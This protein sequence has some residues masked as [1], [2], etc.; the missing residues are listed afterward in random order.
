MGGYVFTADIA[1][2]AEIKVSSPE[3]DLPSPAPTTVLDVA[4]A[5]AAEATTG[6]ARSSWLSAL[7]GRM[8]ITAAAALCAIVGLAAAAPLLRSNLIFKRSPPVVAVMAMADASGDP[9]G[10]VMA[11]E[12]AGR[13]TDGLARI[14][15]ISV[16]APRSTAPQPELAASLA[17]P[18]D[19]EIRGELQRSGPSWTLR[20]RLIQ[21]T[22]GKVEAV[23]AVAVDA[24]ERDPL[25]QQTRLAAGVGDVLARRLNEL[26]ETG[27]SSA[28]GGVTAG[29]ARAAIEQATASINSVTQERFSMAQTMLQNA[30]AEQPDNVDAAVALAALQMRGIQMVWYSPDAAAAAEAQAAANLERALRAKP[31]SIAVLETYCRFL[32]ATNHFV[33]SLIICARTLSLD[34]W[35]G[36]ALYLVGLGQLHLGRFEDALATFQQADRYDTPAVSRWTWL[37]GVG[38]A[39]MMMDRAE[40]A[41]PWLQRSIAITA[42]SGRPY[43]LLAAAYQRAGQ[44]DEA[45][46]A[47]QKGLK[48]RPGTTALNV[49]PPMKNTSPVYREAAARIVQ[50]MVDAGLPAQ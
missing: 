13:L 35:D 22:S 19:F 48:L 43:M 5:S 46:A 42:A 16:I 26:T 29:G 27:T 6:P 30:L 17:A 41:L 8:A 10:A 34:P 24:D 37:L 25:L 31:N 47:I 20:A 11:T 44:I 38:W 40:E 33:E 4:A 14:N 49:A 50:L 36:L 15:T 45:R 9:L 21:T 12:I 28:D 3:V 7:G 32:S 23:G 1:S 2:E 18:P 39:H